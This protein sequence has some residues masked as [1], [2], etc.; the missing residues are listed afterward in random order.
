[1]ERKNIKLK[2]RTIKFRI[3]LSSIFDNLFG[4]QWLVCCFFAKTFFIIFIIKLFFEKTIIGGLRI[5]IRNY[6]HALINL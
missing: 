2:F 1:M 4:L 5:F 6:L 3:F